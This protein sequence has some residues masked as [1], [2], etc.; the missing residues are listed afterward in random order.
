MLVQSIHFVHAVDAS[1]PRGKTLRS[2]THTVALPSAL[3]RVTPTIHY[4][5]LFHRN[6]FRTNF[7]HM[8]HQPPSKERESIVGFPVSHH[9]LCSAVFSV[10]NNLPTRSCTSIFYFTLLPT[11]CLTWH[12]CIFAVKLSVLISA[13]M[14][15]AVAYLHEFTSQS[16][17]N[18]ELRPLLANTSSHPLASC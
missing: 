2:H 1:I 16:S 10:R 17:G 13:L 15:G 18:T 12:V 8:F 3:S 9:Q 11:D 6:L 4:T 5:T 7:L 14:H